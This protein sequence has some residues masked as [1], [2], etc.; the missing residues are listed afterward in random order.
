M[1]NTEKKIRPRCNY[2]V[3][4]KKGFVMYGMFAMILCSVSML[5]GSDTML[6]NWSCLSGDIVSPVGYLENDRAISTDDGRTW[7]RVPCAVSSENAVSSF[8]GLY[9]LLRRLSIGCSVRAVSFGDTDYDGWQEMYTPNY[10]ENAV[11][12]YEFLPRSIL[13]SQPLEYGLP[14]VLCDFN[15]DGNYEIVLQ[16]GDSGMGGNG[17][18][19]IYT[20]MQNGSLV[21]VQ[22]LHFRGA[23]MHYHP[24]AYDL[25]SDG[26]PELIFTTPRIFSSQSYI[27]VA[28]W[29]HVN[30]QLDLVYTFPLKDAYGE[31][32]AADFDQDGQGEFVVPCKS[33]Y[34]VFEMENGQIHFRNYI[35]ELMG[36][37]ELALAWDP[38]GNGDIRLVLATCLGFVPDN[39]RFEI[40]RSIGD[41]TFELETTFVRTTNYV[42]SL[43]GGVGD[44]DNDGMEE[45]FLSFHPTAIMFEWTGT[46]YDSTWAINLENE[47]GTILTTR[48]PTWDLDND[49]FLDWILFD[50]HHDCY[51]YTLDEKGIDQTGIVQPEITESA[52]DC[53]MNTRCY[54]NPSCGIVMFEFGPVEPGEIVSV[55]VFSLDGRLV[56]QLA[57]AGSQAGTMSTAIW[58]GLEAEGSRASSGVYCVRVTSGSDCFVS[59]FTLCR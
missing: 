1:S 29:D 20:L 41:D 51:I 52:T 42:G 15:C 9:T 12:R 44:T 49:S 31:I 56:R 13:L 35:G 48:Y 58:D 37:C 32:A 22:S 25:D 6:D 59:R 36:W 21:F 34:A 3:R 33:E 23:K 47:T 45:A 40:H 4:M 11:N 5:R 24:T 19:D 28:T 55:A 39:W 57:S 18:I 54:P 17:H 10:P 30:S 26:F 14:W 53:R 2:L 7:T 46:Q 8:N 50:H 16:R 38:E 27:R 43:H